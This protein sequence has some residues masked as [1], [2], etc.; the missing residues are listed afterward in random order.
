MS[1]FAESAMIVRMTIHGWGGHKKDRAVSDEIAD[2][3]AAIRRA[4]KYT[5]QLVSS[6]YLK[7]YWSASANLKSLHNQLT[8][9]WLDG[10]QRLLPAKLYWDYIE[11][12]SG[13]KREVEA[14][15]YEFIEK[16]YLPAIERARSEL[17]EMFNEKDYPNP[18]VLEDKFA[19]EIAFSPIPVAS[20]WRVKLTDDI[21]KEIQDDLTARLKEAEETAMKDIWQRTYEA[22]SK[23]EDR[24]KNGK[25]LVESS[26]ENFEELVDLLPK[27]NISNDPNLNKLAAELKLKLCVNRDDVRSDQDLRDS[28]AQEAKDIMSQMSAYMVKS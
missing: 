18:A 15:G 19:I 7:K 11:K 8:V 3:K 4:G 9:P 13:P 1:K 12:V 14:Y 28:K 26:F 5:K 25:R 21:E 16:D 22:I 20:D 10:A 17:G 6:P 24:L 23:M 2:S 27:L